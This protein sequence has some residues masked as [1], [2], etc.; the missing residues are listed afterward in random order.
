MFTRTALPIALALAAVGAQTPAGKAIDWRYY[1]GDQ[2]GSKYSAAAG[3]TRE[4]LS[5]LRIAWEWQ[6]NETALPEQHNAF[7]GNFAATPIEIDG[8]LYV[9]TAYNTVAALEA[10]TGRQLWR[11]DPHATQDIQ[12]QATGW[13]H[14]G[15]T[16]YW[17]D[18]NLRI[19]LATKH[20]LISLDAKTGKPVATF[21]EHGEVDLSKNLRWSFNHELLSNQSA[22]VVYKGYRHRRFRNRGPS[23]VSQ[24]SARGG[25]RITRRR[26]R[27][28][29]PSASFLPAVRPASRH[30]SRSPGSSPATP[31]CG[32]PCRWTPNA[33]SC[34]CRPARRATT[35]TAAAGSART[36][37]PNRWSVSTRSPARA[38]GTSRPCI[39]ASGTTTCRPRLLVTITVNGRTIDAVAQ[40]GKTGMTYVFDRASGAPV[41]PIE[42][43]P[44]PTATD[45]PGE[46]PWATQ[47]FPTRPPP[48]GAQGFTDK[49]VFDLTPQ[50]KAAA[51]EQMKRFRSGPIFTP[52][53]LQGTLVRPTGAGGA[54]WG[55]AAFD[56]ETGRL[57]VKSNETLG[58]AQIQK[59]DKADRRNPY[60]ALSD[61]EW[62]VGGGAS[63]TFMD[64]LPL[65][66][67]PYAHLTAID[68]NAGDIVWRVPFGKGSDRIRKHPAL[69]GMSLPE[70]LGTGA[71]AGQ[72]V[73]KGGLIFVGGGDDAL[74]AFDKRDGREL[75][76]HDLPRRT[77]GTPMTY[78]TAS[79]R[80]FVVIAS[81]G[82]TDASL[83]AFAL[84]RSRSQ[85]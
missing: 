82:G 20:R 47:P 41:W 53:S 72:I 61:A 62:A 52:P 9:S 3:I 7:P 54:N 63:A 56:P 18:G 28:Y 15:I 12:A 60:G 22:P 29:G 85:M 31:T 4:N 37:S 76:H 38:S 69:A 55:G 57:Y 80:Q 14:R 34:S 48:F 44:V 23:D 6:P 26:V 65:S 70:R 66:K 43:R 50:L 78:Q 77:G 58:V 64:G 13:T 42:E 30:G 21:G 68:F 39:T 17:D 49:D 5:N 51:L 1:G 79:G 40:V 67:P 32:R 84:R 73:T 27:N 2:S 19:F 71:A 8:V 11:Y 75:W 25:P 59:V 45:V 24:R 10:E 36:C 81:G 83:V 46:Q 16:P 35:S 33:A 74:Y